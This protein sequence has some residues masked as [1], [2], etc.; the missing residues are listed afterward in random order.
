MSDLQ[1]KKEKD[2][3]KNHEEEMIENFSDVENDF[4]SEDEAEE[5]EETVD[6]GKEVPHNQISVQLSWSLMNQ[7]RYMSKSEGVSPEDLVCELIAEGVTKRVFDDKVR[8]IPSHLM[9]RNGYVN[10]D[11]TSSQPQM[12]HHSMGNHSQPRNNNYQQRNNYP[13]GNNYPPRNNNYQQRNNNSN[14]NGQ[15]NPNQYS[16]QQ[17]F[18]SPNN[19]QNNPNQYRPYSNQNSQNKAN[20]GLYYNNNYNNNNNSSNNNKNYQ[21]QGNVQNPKKDDEE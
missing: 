5:T 20:P 19:K 12:S 21:Q 4:E 16:Q 8:E 10:V 13:S 17:R 3:P 9:T 18:N 2:A 14:Y 7:L 6:F 15:K 11:D 1:N